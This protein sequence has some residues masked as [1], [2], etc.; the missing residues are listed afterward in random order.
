MISAQATSF[1]ATPINFLLHWNFLPQAE[2]NVDQLSLMGAVFGIVY[3]YAVRED[4]NPQLKQGVVGAFALTRAL[5]SVHVSDSC[6]WAPL[7]CGPPLGYLD[8]DMTWQLGSTL[9]ES[10]IAF[11]CAAI[12]IDFCSG[13]K[14][15]RPFP[16]LRVDDAR[17]PDR[18]TT[19]GVTSS[20]SSPL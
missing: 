12:A 8:L 11:S 2:F 9:V 15:L 20:S 1:G 19:N 4:A 13:K 5:S 10:G 6:T 3:R 17:D 7:T 14:W 16:S 18:S